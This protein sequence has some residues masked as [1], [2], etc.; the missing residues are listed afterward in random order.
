MKLVSTVFYL[1]LASLYCLLP[2][3]Q[4]KAVTISNVNPRVGTDGAIMDMHDGNV[5]YS[6]IT[7]SYL[8]TAA[9]YGNCTEPSGD[10]GCTGAAPGA[11]G[12]QLN[13]NVSM[14][15]ST[16]LVTWVPRGHIFQMANSGI[17]NAVLFCPKLLYNGNTKM[18]VLWFN[19]IESSNFANSYYAV[20]TSTSP[21]GPYTVINQNIQS[22]KYKDVGDFNLFMDTNGDA[23]IIYTAH[24]QGYPTTH[25]M[26]VE[27][28]TPDYLSTLGNSSSSGFF[29]ESFVEAP[30]LFSRN[31]IYY[32]VFGQCCCYCKEGS[33]V[34]VYTAPSALGP[35]TQQNNIGI[36]LNYD[37]NGTNLGD[38][39]SAQQTD[40]FA[41][42]DSNNQPNY[43]Y[44]GDRWQSALDHLKAHDFTYWFPLS[45]T[46]DGN[47][48]TMQNI[49][50]FT[51]DI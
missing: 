41:W 21:Y 26:S 34:T 24:I 12:F 5:F 38:A 8:W 45:F 27:K 32:A 46:D 23:Y 15:E 51:I 48:T 50:N 13:H 9:S 35:Y 22:L 3:V 42:Y 16:D 44:I 39:I 40:I 4:S 30:A 33:P 11:C 19:W 29:G 14:Y 49:A 6:T 43:I 7:Q 10:S 20:A 47:I 17:S 25:Q 2:C 37:K 31:G 36:T 1:S 28:L 18:W